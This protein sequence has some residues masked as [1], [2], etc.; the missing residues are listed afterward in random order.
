[1]I[2]RWSP[3]ECRVPRWMAAVRYSA[4]RDRRLD[5]AIPLNLLVALAWRIHDWLCAASWIER[6]VQARSAGPTGVEARVCRDIAARQRMGI[7]K[8][9]YTVEESN[10]DML[11]HVYEEALDLSVYLKR[12][13]EKR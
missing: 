10:D 9:G 12:E 11:Q 5:V 2:Y 1:M 4:E 13:I 3:R 6:E 8:Y 7:A